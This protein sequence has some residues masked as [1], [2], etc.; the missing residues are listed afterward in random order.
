MLVARRGGSGA[1]KPGPAGGDAKGGS[2]AAERGAAA[3]D[4]GLAAL[5]AAAPRDRRRDLLFA[6]VH[7]QALR[8]VG[9]G[10][11]TID[12]RLPLNELGVD[13]LMAVELRNLL[14]KGLGVPAALPATLV[15]DYPTID[16]LPDYI[17]REVLALDGASSPR[18]PSRRSP[19]A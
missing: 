18:R 11:G 14:G 5:I 17:A 7:E 1:A 13:S 12:P 16:A 8:V 4:G 19:R 15:F 9:E 2:P 3:R 10:N 6:F